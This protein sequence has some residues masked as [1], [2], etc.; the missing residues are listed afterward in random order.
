LMNAPAFTLRAT[1][2]A[3]LCRSAPVHHVKVVVLALRDQLGPALLKK[4]C[5]AV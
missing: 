2:A 1:L 4:T 5:Q 3:C